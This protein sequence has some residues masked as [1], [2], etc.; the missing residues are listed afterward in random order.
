M[1]L[2]KKKE[3]VKLISLGVKISIVPTNAPNFSKSRSEQ[4]W[5]PIM[6]PSDPI[7]PPRTPPLPMKQQKPAVAPSSGGW[8][9]DIF[10]LDPKTTV[11]A[12]ETDYVTSTYHDPNTVVTFSVKGCQPSKLPFDL[13]ECRKPEVVQQAPIP[14]SNIF[15]MAPIQFVPN[16]DHIISPAKPEIQQP[17]VPDGNANKETEEEKTS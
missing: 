7:P 10:N 11:T 4:T 5:K 13:P 3:T 2:E 9:W 6:Q 17:K 16:L 8:D 12:T 14:E 1:Y 15:V